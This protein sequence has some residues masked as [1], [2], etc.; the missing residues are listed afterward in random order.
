MKQ[1]LLLVD[2]MSG[3]GKTTVTRLLADK[4]PRTAT[5]GFDKI[6]KFVSDFERGA[7][8]NQIAREVTTVMV[9]KYLDLG[10]SV[11][12][13][14][15]FR[16][17]E[18]IDFYTRV[19]EERHIP[20]HKFQLHADPAVALQRVVARTKENNGDL[21]EERARHNISLFQPRGHLGFKVIDTTNAK[22]EDIAEIILNEI[23]SGDTTLK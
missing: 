14:Q 10:L 22:P 6:K 7:R 21:P 12:I 11:M 1:F 17:E 3:G 19:A 4:L 18:E 23:T 13:E 9:Q 8:D 5:V 2:G 16:N 15:P 20:L